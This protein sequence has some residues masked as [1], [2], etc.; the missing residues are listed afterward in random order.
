MSDPQTESE[1]ARLALL[2][3]LDYGRIKKETAKRLGVTVGDLDAAVRGKRSELGIGASDAQ[4]GQAVAFEEPEQWPEPV[5][6]DALLEDIVIAASRFVVLPLH[7]P[8]KVALWVAHTYVVNASDVTPRLEISAVTPECGKT[9]L[10]DFLSG[11]V[12]RPLISANVTAAAF[13]RVVA[14]HRP[15]LL[16]DEVDSSED[17][18][19]RNVLNS[20]HH[21]SGHVLR[22]VGD[23]YEVR[24]FPCFA[25]VAYAHIG[26]LPRAYSTLTSRSTRIDLKRRLPK[27]EVESLS[28][29]R[30]RNEFADLRRRLKRFADDHRA[31]LAAAEP[32]I[33]DGLVNRLADNWRPLLAI[34]D[35]AGA[36]W[37]E[38]ARDAIGRA[39]RES[40]EREILL[41]DIR[42]LL[43]GGRRARSRPRLW[44]TSWSRSRA[45]PGPKW[46]GT[47]SH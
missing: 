26:E 20:G 21:V 31:A 46:G 30:R 10:L 38:R 16:I 14:Q 47:G 23:D 11:V 15:T 2:K 7:G 44:S 43:G 34:A 1:L 22:T 40:S 12:Y 33:P 39:E 37:P 32:N 45:I 18:D 8:E 5:D 25:P 13:F 27:E 3:P 36:E 28:G 17:S 41:A 35:L 24:A 9:T 42:D 4:Q 29:P 19:I 6:V